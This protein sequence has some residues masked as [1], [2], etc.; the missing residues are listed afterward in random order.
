MATTFPGADISG[1]IFCVR[2]DPGRGPGPAVKDLK[3]NLVLIDHTKALT[4]LQRRATLTTEGRS[5]FLFLRRKSEK[6][7]CLTS[8]NHQF[9]LKFFS[10]GA[11]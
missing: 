7:T 2:A 3:S 6:I 9:R 4:F 10:K 11:R 1:G 5:A 8:K